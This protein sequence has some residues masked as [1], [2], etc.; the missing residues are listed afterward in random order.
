MGTM[1]FSLI[2]GVDAMLPIEVKIP[3]LRISMKGLITDDDY[4]IYLLQELVLLD[5]CRQVACDHL[6]AYQQQMLR[7]YNKKF[8]PRDFQLGDLILR[9]NP[10]N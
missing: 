7:S 10:K 8:K 6:C 3:T 1:P 9:E 5:E 4:I 2:Y